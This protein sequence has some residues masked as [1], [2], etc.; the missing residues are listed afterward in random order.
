MT[1]VTELVLTS[2]VMVRN[3]FGCSN[4]DPSVAD[5]SRT[6]Y[7][8]GSL[9]LVYRFLAAIAQP[10]SDKRVVGALST[11]GEGCASFLKLLLTAEVLCMLTFL[12][13]VVSVS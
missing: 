12:I 13:V 9:S 5:W 8:Y 4:R 2:A 6:D 10:I 11:M 1:A 3:S 7:H